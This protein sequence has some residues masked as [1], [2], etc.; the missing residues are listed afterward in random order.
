MARLVD[1][2]TGVCVLNH[3]EIANTFWTRLVG[4]Q[5]RRSI[6]PGTGLLLSPCSSLHTCFMRFP[7]DI[8]MLDDNNVVVGTLKNIRP[9]RLA[10]CNRG[11]RRVI[12]VPPGSVDIAKGTRLEWR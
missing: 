4:L 12:E 7:I 6:S 2:D 5:F 1:V 10:F 8:V 11:T 9:W 3:L